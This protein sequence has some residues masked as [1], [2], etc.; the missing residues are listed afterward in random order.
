MCDHG[1]PG[2]QRNQRNSTKVVPP[3]RRRDVPRDARY[4]TGETK[5]RIDRNWE[6]HEAIRVHKDIPSPLSLAGR[7]RYVQAPFRRRAEKDFAFAPPIF[8][9][10]PTRPPAS[11]S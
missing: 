7:L 4:R 8:S 3:R 2:L 9:S 10:P 6:R 5:K 11:P 1:E